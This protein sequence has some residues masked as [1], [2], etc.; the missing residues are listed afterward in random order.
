MSTL[1]DQQIA[2]LIMK[3]GAGLLIW[4]LIT[5]SFFQWASEEDRWATPR[6]GLDALEAELSELGLRR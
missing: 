3:L 2:G 5:V 4:L 6:A 1:Q